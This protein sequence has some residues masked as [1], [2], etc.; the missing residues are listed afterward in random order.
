MHCLLEEVNKAPASYDEVDHTSFEIK[1]Q[2]NY[3]S[4]YD[5]NTPTPRRQNS[6]RT[7]RQSN[8]VSKK[9]LEVI[10]SEDSPNKQQS[11]NFTTQ[12]QVLMSFSDELESESKTNRNYPLLFT[13]SL[14]IIH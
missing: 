10:V 13:K 11:P 3:E 6:S 7:G 9:S 1:G 2:L 8:K 4:G 5:S 12:A 14:K